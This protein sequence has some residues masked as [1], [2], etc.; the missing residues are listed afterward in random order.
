M[1]SSHS[2]LSTRLSNRLCCNHTYSL[3][4]IHQ[5]A[6]RQVTAVA[7]HTDAVACPARERAP[8]LDALDARGPHLDVL[9]GDEAREVPAG[10]CDE[11]VVGTTKG[12]QR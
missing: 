1:K 2:K 7:E 3:A 11:I 5:I 12:Y 8:D 6:P 4:D 10:E 9:G